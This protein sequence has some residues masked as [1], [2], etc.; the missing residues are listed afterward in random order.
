MGPREEF[1]VPLLRGKIEHALDTYASRFPAGAKALDVGCGGQPF[2][3]AIESLGF[4]YTAL[5]VQQNPAG[6]VHVLGA[7]DD[8]IPPAIVD[9]GPFQFIMCTEVLEHVADWDRAFANLSTLLA[10]GGRLLITCPHFYP[11]H[12]EPYD[13]WRP[14]RYALAYFAAR[15]GFTILEQHAAGDALAVIGTALQS[16]GL[17]ARSNGIWDRLVRNLVA[18]GRRVLLTFLRNGRLS[19]WVRVDSGMYLANVIVLERP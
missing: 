1:M 14:T 15:Y 18:I 11:L 7:I 17:Y 8:A 5:D 12:E 6:T 10:S 16:C 4:S 19:R 2:R 13:F 3:Q 9:R